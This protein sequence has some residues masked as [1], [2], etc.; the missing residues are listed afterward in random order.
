VPVSPRLL[1]A[2][3]LYFGGFLR[4]FTPEPAIPAFPRAAPWRLAAEE[5][6]L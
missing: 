4:M 6:H 3:S 5:P 2:V 1:A